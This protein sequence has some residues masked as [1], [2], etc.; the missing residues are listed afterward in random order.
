VEALHETFKA[1]DKNGNGMIEANE[2]QTLLRQLG[3]PATQEEA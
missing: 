3:H 2:L 1:F